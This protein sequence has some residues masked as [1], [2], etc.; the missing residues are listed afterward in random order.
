MKPHIICH[1]MPSVDG[2]IDCSMTTEIDK[3]DVYYQV[4]D[5]LKFDAVL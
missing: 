2:R 3:T 1:M 4:L 5:R